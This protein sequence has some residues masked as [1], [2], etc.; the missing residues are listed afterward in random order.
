MARAAR[1]ITPFFLVLALAGV[2]VILVLTLQP[3]QRAGA[4][5]EP[6]VSATDIEVALHRLHL[7][8]RPL[9]AA[10]LSQA[11]T[12][13][14]VNEVQSQLENDPDLLS[15][16]D[17]E[18]AALRS[19]TQA[20]HRSIQGGNYTQNDIDQY[21][22]LTSDYD[23]AMANRQSVLDTLFNDATANLT[24]DEKSTLQTI[25]SNSHW[26]IDTPYQC[27]NRTQVQWVQLRRALH[28]VRIAD[29]S[30]ESADPDAQDVVDNADA[31][32]DVAN[33]AGNIDTSLALVQ[34]AWE[35][36]VQE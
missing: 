4:Q 34:S 2:L 33:A 30:G 20:L 13:D 23:T 25:R 8:P 36:A 14:V 5:S 15:A 17:A 29:A 28:A 27:V 32:P 12:Q 22:Q 18:C 1:T 21:N 16:P 26:A 24:T 6:P 11:D 35:Q 19:Q 31:D 7:D 3:E 9:A 10:G